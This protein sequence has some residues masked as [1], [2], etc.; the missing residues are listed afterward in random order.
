MDKPHR[1]ATLPITL[2]T[3]IFVNFGLVVAIFIL[4]AIIANLGFQNTSLDFQE[5]AT[6]NANA[7][8]IQ[9]MESSVL[10]LQRS[11]L[12]YTQSGYA[13]MVTRV[14]KLQEDLRTRL[15][16]V[17]ES[18]TDPETRVHLQGMEEHFRIYSSSFDAAVEDRSRQEQLVETRIKPL[19][20]Q[21]SALLARLTE[22]AR[23]RNDSRQAALA[24]QANEKLLLAHRDAL[25]FLGRPRSSSVRSAQNQIDELK[26]LLLRMAL[27]WPNLDERH[28]LD[29]VAR[30]VGQYEQAFVE[31]VQT[32]RGYMNLV[33]VVM[34]GE[35]VEFAYLAREL[36]RLTIDH[37]DRVQAQMNATLADTRQFT[38]VVSALATLVAL[39]LAWLVTRNIAGPIKAMTHTL[40]ELARGHAE[41][42]IPG[43]GR[44]DEIGAMAMAADVFKEK[45][46]ELANASRYKSEFLANMSHEL[47]TP[48]NSMLILSRLLAA[49]ERENLTAEQV[50][51]ARVIHDSGTDLLRLINDILDLSKIE[52]GRMDILPETRAL[53]PLR[54]S[55]ER[56]F[57]PVASSKGLEF[58]FM[59]HKGIPDAL[60]T[61]WAAVEQILRNFLSNAFK[62]T[63]RGRISVDV[64]LPRRGLV[65]FD[66]R[67]TSANT[68]AFTVRDTGI[69]I[70]EDKR[71]RIF[72]A[73]R[74]AD[75]TTSRQYGGTGLGLSICRKFA[76]LLGGEIQL[77]SQVGEGSAFT[78]Y[79]PR[80]F[81][82]EVRERTAAT[83]TDRQTPAVTAP[84]SDFRDPTRTL[85]LV[86]DDPRNRYALGKLLAPRV[87][88]VIQAENGRQ[89]LNILEQQ[90][91]R[92]DLVLMDIMMPQMDGFEATRA[93][94]R[95]GRFSRLPII[96][97]T[98]KVMPGDRE[99][100]LE[101]GASDYLPKP[102]DPQRL[103]WMLEEWLSKGKAVAP[104]AEVPAPLVLESAPSAA[105][106][107]PPTSLAPFPTSVMVVDDEMRTTFALA[108]FLQK[109][110]DRVIMAGDGRNAIDKLLEAP[111]VNIILM[112][113]RMP[114]LDGCQATREIRQDPRFATLPILILTAHDSQ[115]D[116]E[117]CLAAG[118]NE[119][120]TKPVESGLLVDRMRHW[121]QSATRPGG[122]DMPSGVILS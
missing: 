22:R 12:A 18:L 66:S 103:L 83:A 120:L 118:A 37:R 10:E 32:T 20:D 48:L 47:R 53:D 14:R 19:Q 65:F 26:K 56:L 93:I 87:L 44:R 119:F 57:G 80:Q 46:H 49:N 100:C 73:F 105:L 11:V 108:Q 78:L 31:M 111:E 52:A 28:H 8:R 117:R 94:R 42:E 51:S 75:G 90:G 61:D 36:K 64:H 2:G 88:E 55:I 25:H 6:I 84:R 85:L 74:Q 3:R 99:K 95:Q 107:A 59:I 39:A 92:V 50:E 89:A 9:E 35:A 15:A 41:A 1:T 33:Y 112:D 77:E 71:E 98:A 21:G 70:P 7:T 62:F 97:L 54:G 115:E 34:A 60:C 86:D 76:E 82:G 16:A 81:P 68:V 91:E 38:L 29:Q 40:T 13:G 110:A 106:S 5:F 67:L 4:Q 23:L 121:L 17:G 45:A 30:V 116:R 109:R 104:M 102:V 101:A 96:A 43:R 69:G 122:G 24:V 113:L 58:Q 63:S 27:E 72:E 79:L 114:N